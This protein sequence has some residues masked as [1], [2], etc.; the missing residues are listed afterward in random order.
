[1]TKVLILDDDP[2]RHREFD[3]ILRGVSRLHVYTADQAISALRNSPPFY[4]V[5]LDHDLGDFD[6]KLLATDPGNGTEVAAYINLHLD[7]GRY[8]KRVMI[9]SWNPVGAR[10]M[11]DLIESVGIPVTVKPFHI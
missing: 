1:M 7:R 11:A 8:P 4:L 9:H 10:R 2:N 3:N 6:N 5:C